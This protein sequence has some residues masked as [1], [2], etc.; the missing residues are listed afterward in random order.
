LLLEITLII[1]Y[2]S[3][4]GDQSLVKWQYR[5]CKYVKTA[6]EM[7]RIPH[8]N[9]RLLVVVRKRNFFSLPYYLMVAATSWN[10][11]RDIVLVTP[12]PFVCHTQTNT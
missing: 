4:F 9:R 12:K 6:M 3:R 2:N 1:G 5:R 10:S 7:E 11:M 8:H